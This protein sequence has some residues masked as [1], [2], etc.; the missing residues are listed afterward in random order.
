MQE[1]LGV[2]NSGIVDRVLQAMKAGDA[3]A[4]G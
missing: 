3:E 4:V 2:V 1:L